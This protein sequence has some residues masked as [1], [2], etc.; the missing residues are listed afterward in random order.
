MDP[1]LKNSRKPCIFKD[2]FSVSGLQQVAKTRQFSGEQFVTLILQ[3]V[4]EGHIPQH[5]EN[6]G[7]PSHGRSPAASVKQRVIWVGHWTFF[8]TPL[9]SQMLH[10][11]LKNIFLEGINKING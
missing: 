1:A 10:T 9:E 8:I 3:T 6:A 7:K 2:W 11:R 4:F 5:H